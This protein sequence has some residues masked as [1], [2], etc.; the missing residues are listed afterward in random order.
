VKRWIQRAGFDSEDLLRQAPDVPRNGMAMRR[1]EDERSEDQEI[2]RPLHLVD[3]L[4]SV[5]YYVERLLNT[6]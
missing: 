3:P 2:E 5:Q 1:T 4:A 6:E